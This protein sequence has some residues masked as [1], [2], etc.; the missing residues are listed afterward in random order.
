MEIY[1]KKSKIV[2]RPIKKEE[3]SCWVSLLKAH[4]YLG[5]NGVIGE[6]INYVAE[7]N[8]EWV[9]LISWAGA[10]LKLEDRDKW[11]GWCYEQK[12]ARLKFIAN[13]WR[14]LILPEYRRPN[15]ASHIL[16]LSLKR[17]SNDWIEKYKHPI[18]MVETFVD[19]ARNKG[20]C[21]I[22]DN[23]I[24][25]GLSKGFCQCYETYNFHGE[26]KII[27]MKSLEKNGRSILGHPWT[28]SILISPYQR[29]RS[30]I[31]PKKIPLFGPKGLIAFCNTVKDSRSKHGKRYQNGPFLA[32]CLLAVFSGMNS[33]KKICQWGKT[34]TPQ[35]L[36]KLKLR[37]APSESGIRD[38][39]LSLDVNDVDQK[40]T[41]WLLASDSLN[42]IALAFDGKT[43]RGSR[44][45][46]NKA[47]QLLSLVTHEGTVIAQRKV[48]NKTN[49]IPVAQE[50]L[51]EMDIRGAILTGDAL[52]TQEKTAT[53]IAREKE[54][55]YVFTVKDNQPTLT[56]EIKNA[57]AQS[58][59]SP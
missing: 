46:K 14:F 32:F 10:A 40:V 38:F 55:D 18:I 9:A 11:I 42:G 37:N 5:F 33:Y 39:I 34:L 25:I 7:E 41:D 31:N 2:V 52:H 45:G 17:L 44:D 59:F 48:D 19:A 49:E 28:N 29:S 15:L 8:G 6:R 26:K 30:V 53:I 27:F 50:L 1:Q 54:A 22:A 57:L 21:Y 35:H 16:S 4:H 23:W 56:V 24:R 3:E 47:I 12:I 13:N 36:E 51:M 43:L 58:A 20:T